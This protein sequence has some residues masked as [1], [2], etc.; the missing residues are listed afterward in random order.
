MFG[1]LY[2][3]RLGYSLSSVSNSAS[4]LTVLQENATSGE[5]LW[6]GTSVSGDF[7]YVGEAECTVSRNIVFRMLQI[8]ANENAAETK[9]QQTPFS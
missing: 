1:L 3:L 9:C 5:H 2:L 4:T 7:C 8:D 6:V